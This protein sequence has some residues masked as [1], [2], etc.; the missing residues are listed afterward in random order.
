MSTIQKQDDIIATAAEN[1]KAAYQALVNKGCNK[2]SLEHYVKMQTKPPASN[3]RA[4]ATLRALEQIT[5]Q[6]DLFL[7]K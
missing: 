7:V 3:A 5:G 4:T 2:K 6:S 1:K